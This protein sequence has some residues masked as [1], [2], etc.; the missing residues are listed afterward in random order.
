MFKSAFCESLCSHESAVFTESVPKEEDVLQTLE[1]ASQGI[2]FRVD[3][4]KG[5]RSGT[6]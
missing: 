4:K 5:Q 3:L 6:G 1:R 2:A